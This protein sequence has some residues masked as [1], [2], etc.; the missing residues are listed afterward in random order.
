[1]GWGRPA[2]SGPWVGSPAS[3]V[4]GVLTETQLTFRPSTQQ[5]KTNLGLLT[6]RFLSVCWWHTRL[7]LALSCSSLLC[8]TG[9]PRP[10]CPRL[11]GAR[12]SG[13]P[14]SPLLPRAGGRSSTNH[15]FF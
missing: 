14:P 5:P 10:P 8:P 1:M 11:P 2:V 7:S 15:C 13:A 6:C 4:C 12:Q 9:P 3:G